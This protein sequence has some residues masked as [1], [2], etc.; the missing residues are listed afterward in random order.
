MFAEAAK[1]AHGKELWALGEPIL[2]WCQYLNTEM[3]APRNLD[4]SFSF[5]G[6]PDPCDGAE[7]LK[8]Q[9]RLPAWAAHLAWAVWNFLH[10]WKSYILIAIHERLNLQDLKLF[11]LNLTRF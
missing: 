11:R 4:S 9:G 5:Q 3:D 6:F 10:I 1:E 8:A 2:I 7:I